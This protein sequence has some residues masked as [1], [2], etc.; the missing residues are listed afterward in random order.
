MDGLECSFWYQ[1]QYKSLLWPLRPF[2]RLS[3][4]WGWKKERSKVQSPKNVLQAP[5]PPSGEIE[6]LSRKKYSR[7]NHETLL[8]LSDCIVLKLLRLA[9]LK[10]LL[11]KFVRSFVQERNCAD[12]KQTFVNSHSAVA[13]FVRNYLKS[14]KFKWQWWNS[15]KRC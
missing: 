3:A 12:C 10:R 11:S 4:S 14:L 13:D 1:S 2:L 5:S 7:N 9:K 15:R 6:K 8:K